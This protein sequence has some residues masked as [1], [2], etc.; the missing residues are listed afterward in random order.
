M[1]SIW[2]H[3][4]LVVSQGRFPNADRRSTFSQQVG[5]VSFLPMMHQ[6]LQREP[7]RGEGQGTGKGRQRRVQQPRLEAHTRAQP[8][9][10]AGTR[11]SEKWQLR[12]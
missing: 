12:G 9:F 7:T 3:D 2:I 8:G 5:H 11:G 10:H 6:P 4:R 1:S